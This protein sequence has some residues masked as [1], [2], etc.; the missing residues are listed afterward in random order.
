MWG[1]D[2][3][4]KAVPN[5]N[6]LEYDPQKRVCSLFFSDFS[7]RMDFCVFL[8]LELFLLQWLVLEVRGVTS[9]VP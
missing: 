1:N 2:A 6:H 9:G 4:R 7:L 5:E 3:K 8:T